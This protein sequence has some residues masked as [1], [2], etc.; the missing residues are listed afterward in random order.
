M[1]W[2]EADERTTAAGLARYAFEYIEAARLIDATAQTESPGEMISPMPA[3]F[4]ASHGI[5]LTLKAFLRHRGVRVRELVKLG[6]SLER[7][8]AVAKEHGLDAHF[9]ELGP[10]SA[11]FELLTSL[12]GDNHALR[13]IS[14]GAKTFP[15]WAVVEPLAVRLHQAVGPVVGYKTFDGI[16]YSAYQ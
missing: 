15:L 3:Y 6:H 16:S 4:L 9:S 12:N 10:D 5:E 8:N 2:E 7:C 1:T 14:T 13:Y 11:A